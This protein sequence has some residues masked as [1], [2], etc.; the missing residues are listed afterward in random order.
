M[1]KGRAGTMTH[2]YNRHGTTSWFA[3]LDV[4]TPTTHQECLPP[5]R[6]ED[7]LM[8][9]TQM[10]RSVPKDHAIDVILV[11]AGVST[12]MSLR[13]L[14]LLLSLMRVVGAVVTASISTTCVNVVIARWVARQSLV[15]VPDLPVG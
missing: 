12:P 11:C 6:R 8:F 3:E 4:A 5:H 1:K 10:E 9:L 2:D 13:V 7:F 14:A 15:S